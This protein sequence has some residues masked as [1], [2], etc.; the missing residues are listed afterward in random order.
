MKIKKIYL[1]LLAF[2]FIFSI[3]GCYLTEP[4]EK[5]NTT[6]IKYGSYFYEDWGFYCKSLIFSNKSLFF[7]DEMTARVVIYNNSNNDKAIYASGFRIEAKYSNGKYINCYNYSF[8]GENSIIIRALSS[9]EVNVS[10]NTSN[11]YASS[12]K[13]YY[14]DICLGSYVAQY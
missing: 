6:I 7:D 10:C 12:W 3:S 5:T 8:D 1:L 2:F 4:T 9:R 11:S 14:N 13:V